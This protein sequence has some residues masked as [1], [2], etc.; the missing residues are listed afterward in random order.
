[1]FLQLFLK[2]VLAQSNG[3]TDAGKMGTATAV[4][5]SCLPVSHCFSTSGR[6]THQVP[7]APPFVR[8]FA[9]SPPTASSLVLMTVVDMSQLAPAVLLP[10][11][12]AAGSWTPLVVMVLLLAVASIGVV[13]GG[14][15]CSWEKNYDPFLAVHPSETCRE[16][17][18]NNKD[19]HEARRACCFC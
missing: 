16:F 13:N 17:L 7:L 9:L 6:L 12:S 4:C 15:V 14:Q 18:T 1:M 11:S 3:A 2:G 8:F 5:F 19:H 10:R